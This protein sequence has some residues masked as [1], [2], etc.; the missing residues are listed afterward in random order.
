MNHS[1]LILK[2]HTYGIRN[3]TLRWIQAFLNKR[4]QRIV[5]EDEESDS[6][7]VTTGV[8]QCSVLG[9]ILF[10][11]YI[12]DL[13]QDIVSQVRLFAD[14]TAIYLKLATEHDS[15]ILQKDLDRLQAWESKWNMEFNPSKCQVVRVTSSRTSYKTEFVLH[16]QVLDTV[17]S[18]RYLGMDI[19]NNLNRNT[20][21]DR[22]ALNTNRSLGFVKRNLKTKSQKVREMAYQTLVRPQLEYA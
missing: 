21:V 13:P 6:I 16:G 19:S 22:I 12:N 18:A 1:K 11:V 10:L 9:P 15:D 14:D 5:F 20:H 2:L 7:P 17:T 3:S 8:A 4:K